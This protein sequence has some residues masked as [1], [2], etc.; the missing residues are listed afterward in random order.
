MKKQGYEVVAQKPVCVDFSDGRSFSFR[1][2]HR[3]EADAHNTTVQRLLRVGEIRTLGAGELVPVMPVTLGRVPAEAQILQ[4]R[5]SL[6][7]QN[8]ANAKAA[9]AAKM[10]ASKSAAPV[11]EQAKP[12][13]APRAG[14]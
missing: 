9:S 14:K 5:A 2:G 1:P 10:S 6:D 4:T 7:Q 8:I 11:I 12:P 13:V 3:F